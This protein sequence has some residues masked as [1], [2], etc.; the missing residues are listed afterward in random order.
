MDGNRIGRHMKASSK[1]SSSSGRSTQKNKQQIASDQARVTAND[2]VTGNESSTG[3]IGREIELY[4]HGS[5]WTRMESQHTKLCQK[6]SSSTGMNH[7]ALNI[8][9]EIQHKRNKSE[10]SMEDSIADKRPFLL[11]T[12]DDCRNQMAASGAT[13]NNPNADVRAKKFPCEFCFRSYVHKRNL[14]VRWTHN[15]STVFYFIIFF[16]LF[17]LFFVP[18]Q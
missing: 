11:G 18:Q 9:K 6:S 12:P 4:S 14:R 3:K 7:A 17:V 8:Q 1:H 10:K 2:I 13:I 16:Q 5:R 15:L